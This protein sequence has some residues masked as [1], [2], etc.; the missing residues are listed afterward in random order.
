M[1]INEQQKK[2]Q[3]TKK[4]ERKVLTQKGLG[5]QKMVAEN[6]CFLDVLLLTCNIA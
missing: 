1:K 4:R 5:P 2:Y 3:N 6:S